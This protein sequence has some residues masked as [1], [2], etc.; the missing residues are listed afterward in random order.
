VNF[1]AGIGDVALALGSFGV[2]DGHEYRAIT[3]VGNVDSGSVAYQIGFWSAVAASL[4]V[5][6]LFPTRHAAAGGNMASTVYGPTIAG[7]LPAAIANTFRGGSYV[8][9]TLT[10]ATVFY[11]VYGGAAA[12]VSRSGGAFLTRT[13]PSGPLQAMID[14]ALNPQWGNT[15]SLVARVRVPAGTTIYEGAAAAQGGLVGGGNQVFIPA[16]NPTWI[17]P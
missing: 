6:A 15:A 14:L 11:R 4:G 10:E 9:T 12:Q 16:V 8:A 17:I 1:L 7:P 5:G 2:S 13:A 3:G